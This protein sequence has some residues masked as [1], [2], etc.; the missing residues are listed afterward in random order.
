MADKQS[1]KRTEGRPFSRYY[2]IMST[3]LD[4]KD[5]HIGWLYPDGVLDYM[6]EVERGPLV[7]PFGQPYTA[8]SGFPP[9]F[10]PPPM[11]LPRRPAGWTPGSPLPISDVED[12][13]GERF[14]VVSDRARRL[15]IELDPDAFLFHPLSVVF[16]PDME[17]YEGPPYWLC[18]VV[19][20]LDA[21]DL[22]R[23]EHETKNHGVAGTIVYPSAFSEMYLKSDVVFEKYIFRPAYSPH[24]VYCSSEFRDAMLAQGMVARFLKKGVV[25]NA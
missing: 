25:T 4:G 12:A 6:L 16:A 7:H 24:N 15:F 13:G 1:S 10:A 14:W 22:E 18:D 2:E 5:P 17:P 3:W 19:R 11:V 21:I 9:H 20:Y 23:T 8:G